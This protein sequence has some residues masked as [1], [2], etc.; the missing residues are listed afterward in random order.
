MPDFDL[1][2]LRELMGFLDSK[3]AELAEEADRSD[4]PDMLGLYERME[5]V[6]GLGF[7][8]CQQYLTAKIGRDR[9][10][11]KL[12]IS[13]GPRH[14][15]GDPM[16]AIVNAAAN[17]WKHS[18]EWGSRE[19]PSME[20]QRDQTRRPLLNLGVDLQ[21][22]YPLSCVLAALLSPLPIQFETLLPFL[23]AWRDAWLDERDSSQEG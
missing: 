12:A 10:Q 5:Y 23:V 3:L 15:F 20:A 9:A 18:S 6:Y 7:A 1:S 19:D 11:R 4:D 22:P 21:G 17:Y 14:R 2:F 16:A 8:A 13:L